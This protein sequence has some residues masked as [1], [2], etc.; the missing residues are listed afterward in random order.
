[1]ARDVHSSADLLS[2]E[3]GLLL[4]KWPNLIYV[5]I[6]DQCCHGA[7][8]MKNYDSISTWA[9]QLNFYHKATW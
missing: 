4:Y 1:M 8:S 7:A 3:S 9:I 6:L 5:P 2:G